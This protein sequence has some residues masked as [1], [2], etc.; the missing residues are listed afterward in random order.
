VKNAIVKLYYDLL[1]GANYH[2]QNLVCADCGHGGME[3]KRKLINI[4][5]WMGFFVREID[6]V[7][8]KPI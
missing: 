8:E 7:T 4:K 2:R 3:K 6:P 1:D 5:T